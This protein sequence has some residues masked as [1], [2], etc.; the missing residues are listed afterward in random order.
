MRHRTL[1]KPVA[2][3]L[4][5]SAALPLS[6][7]PTLCRTTYES[8]SQNHGT[9]KTLSHPCH[10]HVCIHVQVDLSNKSQEFVELYHSIIP[11]KDLKERVPVLVHGNKRLVDSAVIVVRVC[12]S[13]C[14][15][16]CPCVHMRA[17]FKITAPPECGREV[18]QQRMGPWCVRYG[19]Q[20]QVLSG[21]FDTSRSISVHPVHFQQ[22][23][24][25][26]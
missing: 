6:M 3:L 4:L 21:V 9:M 25:S 10:W 5:L 11:D 8:S 20:L 18:L 14:A 23:P 1:K 15:C 7:A 13:S 12:A 19:S 24:E 26:A 17:C 22:F 2:L 16:A